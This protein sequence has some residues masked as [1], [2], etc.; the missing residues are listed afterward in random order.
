MKRKDTL[1]TDLQADI[2][3]HRPKPKP[4]RS[5]ANQI[6]P[7]RCLV[8]WAAAF[9]SPQQQQQQQKT[10]YMFLFCVQASKDVNNMTVKMPYQCFING[11]FED[12]ENGKTYDTINPN[13]GSVS[14]TSSLSTDRSTRTPTRR[15]RPLTHSPSLPLLPSP[16]FPPGHLQ[17]VLRLRGRRGPGSGGGKGGVRQ[18][19]VGQDEPQRQRK[20]ALQVSA[21]AITCAFLPYC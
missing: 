18:R 2:R 8:S 11:Q 16:L 12:A 20:S 1:Y 15:V 21:V 9:I 5:R 10:L 17:G 19:A 3:I 4:S 13:D 7:H 14:H 6:T